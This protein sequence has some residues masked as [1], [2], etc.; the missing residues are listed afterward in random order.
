MYAGLAS[1]N[2]PLV[3]FATS[4]EH[5]LSSIIEWTF[6]DQGMHIR[7]GYQ[8][9]ALRPIFFNAELLFHR[10][11]NVYETYYGRLLAA[12]TW[13][14]NRPLEDQYFWS[15]VQSERVG[16]EKPLT[17]PTNL[18][19]VV[20]EEGTVRLSW[21]DVSSAAWF[22]I[23]RKIGGGVFETVGRV[24]GRWSAFQEDCSASAGYRVR[25]TNYHV[26]DS[27]YSE[28]VCVSCP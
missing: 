22:V 2:W 11:I 15:F 19:A 3:A 14:G 1:R 18:T 28:V 23:E 6:T 13:R 9:Y 26:G 7:D 17:A 20:S 16:E 24:P 5:G 10:G 4:S 12:A 21:S 27:P 25:A 8:T